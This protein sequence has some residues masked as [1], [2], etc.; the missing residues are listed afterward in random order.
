MHNPV[1]TGS[2]PRMLC[3]LSLIY[4]FNHYAMLLH[5]YLVTW[6]IFLTRVGLGYNEIVPI[7]V[8]FRMMFQS[9]QR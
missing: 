3:I 5:K 2:Q 4:D 9:L 7:Y 8:S 6:L 1:T